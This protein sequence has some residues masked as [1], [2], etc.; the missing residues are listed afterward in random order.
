MKIVIN[1]AKIR[2]KAMPFKFFRLIAHENHANVCDLSC[3]SLR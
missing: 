1:T 3:F 2:I